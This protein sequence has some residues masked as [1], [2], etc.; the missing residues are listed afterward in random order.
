M[1]PARRQAMSISPM[2]WWM[3]VVEAE[4]TARRTAARALRVRAA[5]GARGGWR[6]GSEA[7]VAWRREAL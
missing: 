2:T 4:A 5:G 6:W 7:G 1:L 3:A